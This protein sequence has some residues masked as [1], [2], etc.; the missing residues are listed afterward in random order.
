VNSQA[1]A[2]AGV[3]S[4]HDAKLDEKTLGAYMRLRQKGELPLC[5]HM[6]VMAEVLD[7][8]IAADLPTRFGDPW[9]RVG[10]PKMFIDGGLG[11]RTAAQT[12]PHQGEPDNYG[13]LW[14]EQEPLN[15]LVLRAHL[16]V[17]CQ[18]HWCTHPPHR[19][20]NHGSRF[21]TRFNLACYCPICLAVV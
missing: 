13:I 6:M 7:F 12:E 4:V 21:S 14:M 20:S 17:E 9:L 18:S 1:L 11:A 19:A 2:L 8:L 16:S 10:R 5:F 15:E 3:T